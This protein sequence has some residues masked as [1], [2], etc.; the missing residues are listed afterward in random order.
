MLFEVYSMSVLSWVQEQIDQDPIPY[1]LPDGSVVQA[2]THNTQ[3]TVQE[4]FHSKDFLLL[5]WPCIFQSPRTPLLPPPDWR[6][7]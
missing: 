5:G 1:Q 7:E 3:C 6:R 4:L 2:S